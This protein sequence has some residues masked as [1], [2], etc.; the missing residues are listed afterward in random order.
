MTPMTYD[1]AMAAMA[2]RHSRAVVRLAR[3]PRRRPTIP[4]PRRT[5]R[6]C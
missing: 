5:D 1:L 4:T 2:V 6:S 3:T